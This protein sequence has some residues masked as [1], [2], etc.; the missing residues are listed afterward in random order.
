MVTTNAVLGAVMTPRRLLVL[1]AAVLA[2]QSTPVTLARAPVVDSSWRAQWI[3]DPTAPAQEAGVYHFRKDFDLVARPDR[4]VVRISADNRYRLFV[5]EVEVSN[6]PARSDLMHWRYETVD[7]AGQL[8]PGHNVV[9]ALVWNFG[10]NRPAAQLSLRTAFLMQGE[11]ETESVVDTGPSWKVLRDRGYSFSPVIGEDSGGYYVA[12]PNEALDANAYPWGWERADTDSSQWPAA[13]PI[14][15]ATMRGAGYAG[16]AKDWQLTARNIPAV[17][18]HPVRFAAVRRASGIKANDAFLRGDGDL[19]IPT[20]SHVSILVDQRHLALGYPVLC[21]SGGRG[22]KAVLTYAEALFDPSGHKGNRNEI[23]GKTIRGVRDRF[24]FDGGLERCFQSLWLRTFRYVQMDIE[25]S[26]EPLRIHDFHSI[27]AAYPFEQRARFNSDVSWIPAIWDLDW[28]ALRLSAFETFW[29]SPYYEQLQY[30]GDTRIESLLSVYLT[31]DDRLMRNA[32]EQIDSSRTYEGITRSAYP[33]A[34]PQFI[35][36]FSLWWIAMVHDYWMLRDDPEFVRSFLPGT[37]SVISWFEGYIDDTG[38]L[39]HLP[40]WN[41][42]DWSNRF[43]QGGPPGAKTG[44]AT[45]FTLQFALVLRQA[46][47]LEDALGQPPEAARYRELA[48]KLVAAARARAWDKQRGLFLDAPEENSFS[49]QTNTLA[50]LA[51][52]V[53]VAEQKPVMQRILSDS[54][55][56]QA[57]FYF[58]FYVDEALWKSGLGDRYVERLGPWR[59][60]VRNGLTATAETPEPTRSD[61]HAWSAHPNYHLLASVLGIRPQSPGFRSVIV[62]PAFGEMRWMTGEVPHP[63]GSIKV[64][65]RRLGKGGVEAH[66]ELPKTVPGEFRWNERTVPLRPGPNLVRCEAVCSSGG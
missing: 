64:Q 25:T 35:P 44:H 19:L 13:K 20:N 58:R 40:W 14:A 54:S 37:R 22:A 7:I 9:A 38:M 48:D 1:A 51:D 66:I 29:D 57:S 30:V 6:G 15:E 53:S 50:L 16:L 27:F 43:D 34:D 61:S 8:H 3:T 59:E 55:L 39:A 60:M 47:E 23:E 11:S 10:Q 49:Q 36:S 17:E 41:F 56:I 46:A 33:S 26:S 65:V 2:W 5:N 52:A 42:L 45:A 32:I 4:F 12:G 18:Q 62:A 28:H 63:Q 21:T 31:G 24:R